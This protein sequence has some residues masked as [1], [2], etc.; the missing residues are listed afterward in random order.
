MNTPKPAPPLASRRDFLKSSSRAAI[1]SA[2]AAHFVLTSRS[3]AADGPT[4]RIGLIGCGGRGT[5]AASQALKAHPN[6]VLVAM[7]DAF[8]NRLHNSLETLRQNHPGQVQVEPDHCFVGLDAY[9]KVMAT[10]VD[11]VLLTTP[12]GFRPAH[13]KAAVAAG[14]HVF[15]EKPMAVDAPGV[16]SVLESAQ[17]AKAANLALVAGFCYRYNQGCRELVQRVHDGAIGEVRALYN[18]YNAG[19]VWPPFNREPGWT[20]AQYQ[21]KN[22]YYYNHLSG[23]HIVEQACHSLDKMAWMMKDEPPLRCVAHGGRQQRVDPQCGNIFDHFSVVYDYPNGVKGYHF[24]RQQSGCFNDNSDYITGTTG[25][26]QIIRAISGPFVLKDNRDQL[27]W[28]FRSETPVDMYQQEHNELFASIREGK[29][30]NDGEWMAHS[31]LLALMGRMAAYTGQQITW[32]QALNSEQ[33]MMPENWLSWDT[34]VEVLPVAVPGQ[35][36]FL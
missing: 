12:P 25:V 16:R 13:L 34:P 6:N 7:A 9:L 28:R 26:A 8:D 18:T 20:D 14:K 5:G 4:L 32:E 17:V 31:T 1:T 19:L 23:D 22:W 29:P 36:Q 3:R 11:V 35:T 15:T 33:Q 21:V 10:D 30:I 27:T 2:L 24:C